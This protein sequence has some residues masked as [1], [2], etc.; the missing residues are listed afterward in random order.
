M[1]AEH[2]QLVSVP[3]AGIERGRIVSA[4]HGRTQGYSYFSAPEDLNI[5]VCT[6]EDLDT[7]EFRWFRASAL[8]PPE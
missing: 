5:V 6:V 1:Y 8:R 4:N 7:G 2:G 3:S